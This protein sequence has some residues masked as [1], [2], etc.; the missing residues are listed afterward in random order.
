MVVRRETAGQGNKRAKDGGDI[1]M[2]GGSDGG[3]GGDGDCEDAGGKERE[4]SF[5]GPRVPGAP[6]GSDA[7]RKPEIEER[8]DEARLKRYDSSRAT[9]GGGGNG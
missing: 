3:G 5:D 8:K 9:D 7:D 2:E 4:A 6:A 1:E